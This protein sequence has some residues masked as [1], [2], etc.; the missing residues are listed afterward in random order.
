MAA[1]HPEVREI[2]AAQAL[3]GALPNQALKLTQVVGCHLLFCG[4]LGSLVPFPTI[5]LRSLAPRR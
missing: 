1:N 4:G 2:V 3:K 5:L